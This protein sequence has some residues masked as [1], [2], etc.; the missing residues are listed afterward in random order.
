MGHV[1]SAE[2][3]S[4]DPEMDEVVANW[5]TPTVVAEFLWLASYSYYG[6]VL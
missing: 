6:N 4:T 1:I 3:V 5:P 2:R